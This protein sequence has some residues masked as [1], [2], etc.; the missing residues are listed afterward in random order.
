MK[1]R[2]VKFPSITKD[3]T[4]SLDQFDD[5]LLMNPKAD[6]ELDIKASGERPDVKDSEG[7]SMSNVKGSKESVSSLT[8]DAQ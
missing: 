6:P 5:D 1:H 3:N 7:N 8:Q 2:V 4:V